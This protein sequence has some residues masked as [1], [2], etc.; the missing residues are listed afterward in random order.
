MDG[1]VFLW[2]WCVGL[3]DTRQRWLKGFAGWNKRLLLIGRWTVAGEKWKV[4][5]SGTGFSSEKANLEH[6]Q[7]T[8]LPFFLLFC[9][10]LLTSTGFDTDRQ[11]IRKNGFD[12]YRMV[13][14][15]FSLNNTRASIPGFPNVLTFPDSREIRNTR[16]QLV[17]VNYSK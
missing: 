16:E 5:W 7:P 9:R 15:I 3:V 4:T 11:R 13:A 12:R 10:S 2:H 1:F 14:Q 6:V 17:I 8:G